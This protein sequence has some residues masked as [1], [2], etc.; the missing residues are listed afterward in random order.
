MNYINRLH[1]SRVGI[2]AEIPIIMH[3]QKKT[4]LVKRIILITINCIRTK[5]SL[6]G[7][8]WI[9]KSKYIYMF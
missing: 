9:T 1:K 4:V 2:M 6:R 8:Y 5:L 3:F 7:G